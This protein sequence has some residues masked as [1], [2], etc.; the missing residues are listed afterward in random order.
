MVFLLIV[1]M[2]FGAE[3]VVLI[4]VLA[5][6]VTL[7]ILLQADVTTCRPLA[8]GT[9]QVVLRAIVAISFVFDLVRQNF[10]EHH[11]D[12]KIS[13]RK[14]PHTI[15]IYYRSYLARL[16]H[17]AYLAYI[18]NITHECIVYSCA[19]VHRGNV[20]LLEVAWN[21]TSVH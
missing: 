6:N 7:I 13:R 19:R 4:V 3:L 21:I 17:D 9:R 11:H 10:S 1:G 5:T 12:G 2:V 15:F 8:I 16:E 18:V 14:F 20:P